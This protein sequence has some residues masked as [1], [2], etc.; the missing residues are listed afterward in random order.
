MLY[1]VKSVGTT[2]SKVD[3]IQ[4]QRAG[5]EGIDRLASL[6]AAVKIYQYDS[7]LQYVLGSKL[8]S[9]K[10]KSYEY[11]IRTFAPGILFLNSM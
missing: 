8:F 2:I 3:N 1:Y 7:T 4:L 10:T 11:C 5:R 6:Q 9:C